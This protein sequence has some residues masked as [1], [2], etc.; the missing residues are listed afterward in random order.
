VARSQR[1]QEAIIT[2]LTVI[3]SIAWLVTFVI[4]F[5]HSFEG[6]AAVDAGMLLVIGFWFSHRGLQPTVH[7]DEKDDKVDR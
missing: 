4:R 3:I 2:G 6:S 7:K 1:A 5:F